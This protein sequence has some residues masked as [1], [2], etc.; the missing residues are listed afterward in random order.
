M[1]MRNEL[2]RWPESVRRSSTTARPWA[3]VPWLLVPVTVALKALV[4]VAGVPAAPAPVARAPVAGL[5]RRA[6]TAV[7]ALGAAPSRDA[8]V[9]ARRAQP[10]ASGPVGS[11]TIRN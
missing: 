11:Q 1:W 2:S 4:G 5:D 6:V 10:F 8:G 9:P 3:L 7:A